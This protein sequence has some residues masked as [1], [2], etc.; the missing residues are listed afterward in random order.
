VCSQS[1]HCG[2]VQEQAGRTAFVHGVSTGSRRG[3]RDG[4]GFAFFVSLRLF[5]VSAVSHS[6]AS[7]ALAAMA[8]FSIHR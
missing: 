4:F 5:G 3:G 2:V 6:W 1:S 8:T 7:L